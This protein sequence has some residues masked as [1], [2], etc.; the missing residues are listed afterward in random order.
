MEQFPDGLFVT[1]AH[2]GLFAKIAASGEALLN[3]SGGFSGFAMMLAASR[4]DIDVMEWHKAQGADINASNPNGATP[5]LLA[6]ST[7]SV[8]A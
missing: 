1:L 5:I 7:D 2:R 8:K 4:N 3:E 6:A